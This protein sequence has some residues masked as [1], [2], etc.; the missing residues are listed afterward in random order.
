MNTH[1]PHRYP[2]LQWQARAAR[3]AAHRVS[4]VGEWLRERAALA[5]YAHVPVSNLAGESARMYFKRVSV[6]VWLRERAAL[7]RYA[8]VPVLQ[9][10][11]LFVHTGDATVAVADVLFA[12]NLRATNHLLWIS[13]VTLPDL[14]E[15]VTCLL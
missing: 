11:L 9:P 5:R 15:S 12:R 13:D 3:R 2:P 8:H 6:I 10:F 14:G 4:A 1:T 7:A